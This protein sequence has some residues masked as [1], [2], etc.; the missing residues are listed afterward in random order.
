MKDIPFDM[1]ESYIQF[2]PDFYNWKHSA[3]NLENGISSFNLKSE[4][5][6]CSTCGIYQSEY[7]LSLANMN[8]SAFMIIGQTPLDVQFETE[9]GKVLA[10]ALRFH[11]FNFEQ[12]Y[13][14][15]LYKFEDSSQACHK[16][17]ASELIVVKPTVVLALGYEVGAEF[18]DNIQAAG[19][20][21]TLANGVD[22]LVT[23]SMKDIISDHSCYQE[24]YSHVGIV[25]NQ[26]QYRLAQGR[27]YYEKERV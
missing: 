4:I 5:I 18:V 9:S 20:G 15:S 3:I 24:F 23:H 26:L 6:N 17:I 8:G 12:I 19:Q 2:N 21:I 13:R 10:E 14:T 22:I 1:S 27:Q 11:Q 16:H 25:A 7:P